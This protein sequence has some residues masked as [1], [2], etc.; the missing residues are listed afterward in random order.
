MKIK[1]FLLV[2]MIAWALTACSSTI[3]G[4]TV[5]E[6]PKKQ[7]AFVSKEFLFTF[8][9]PQGWTEVTKDL[10]TKWAIMDANQNLILFTVNNVQVYDLNLLGNF[11]AIRDLYQ[12]DNQT[13]LSKDKMDAIS[14]IV[15]IQEFNNQKFYTYA[16]DFKDKGV[17]SIVSGTIC[18]SKEVTLVLVAHTAQA[19]EQ[20]QLYT[21]LLN[22]FSC[23]A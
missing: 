23:T 5:V 8:N 21:D 10:P 18:G 13:G 19:T 11:Q 7:P 17:Q 1:S 2:L 4:N 6:V 20:Q 14:K 9:Y 16:I 15:K 22:T 12:V 3:T